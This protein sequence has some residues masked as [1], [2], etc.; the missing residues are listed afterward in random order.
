[1]HRYLRRNNDYAGN[2]WYMLTKHTNRPASAMSDIVCGCVSDYTLRESTPIVPTLS[3][4]RHS[5]V[6]CVGDH[7]LV[8]FISRRIVHTPHA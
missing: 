1:M 5:S 4:S 2:T 3:L 7:D 8:A 6:W